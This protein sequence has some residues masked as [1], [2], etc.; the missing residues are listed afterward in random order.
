MNL[1]GDPWIPVVFHNGTTRV[2]GLR[3]LYEQAESIRDLALA[4]PQRIAVTRL[5]ICI[6]QAALDGPSDLQ[7]WLACT[8]RIIPESLAYL[9]ARCEKFD[10]F[11]ETPF[12]Q[13][14][15][16]EADKLAPL[17]KLDFGLAAGNNKTLFDQAAIPDGREHPAGWV[18]LQ[19]LTFLNF[20]TGGKVGQANWKKQKFSDST[21]AAPTLQAAH[22]FPRG[23]NLCGTL[24]LN[25]LTKSQI[26]QLPNGA[27]GIPV[28]DTYPKLPNDKKAIENATSTYLGRL[29]PLTRLLKIYQKIDDENI[30]QATCIIGPPPKD[31]GFEGPPAFREPSTTLTVNQKGES[32][33][34]SVSVDKHI[35]RE[36]GAVLVLGKTSDEATGPLTLNNLLHLE[37]DTL[38]DIWIG[39]LLP[40]KAD[41]EDAVEW[42]ISIPNSALHGDQ[43]MTRYQNSV[44][45]AEESSY[46]L[47]RAVSTYL[48]EVNAYKGNESRSK[49]TRAGIVKKAQTTYW[50]VLDQRYGMLFENANVDERW[51]HIIGQALLN[52]YE[53]SCPHETPRQIQAFSAGQRQLG[54]WRLSKKGE[55]HV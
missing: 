30:I 43:L 27:W 38:V 19:L 22:T 45:V 40:S 54:L 2:V 1:I 36:L 21:K 15:D 29:V 53:Q 31:L 13:I 7:D 52:A 10:L 33:Y 44:Q 8:S 9:D 6:T 20:S 55:D 35:W 18:A 48:D 25:L 47:K 14:K 26:T 3:E 39:G 51:K 11:G 46:A 24:Y 34:L 23:S 37:L 12:M 32:G 41:I 49:N 50:Q 16:L 17:D 4:P 42:N 5:L 28:W